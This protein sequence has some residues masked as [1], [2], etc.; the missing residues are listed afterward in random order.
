MSNQFMGNVKQI[1]VKLHTTGQVVGKM[2]GYRNF[3][4]TKQTIFDYVPPISE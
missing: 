1:G 4:A 2:S 3:V